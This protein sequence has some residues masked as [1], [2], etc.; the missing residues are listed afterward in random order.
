MTIIQTDS[1]LTFFFQFQV[2]GTLHISCC[3]DLENY[4]RITRNLQPKKIKPVKKHLKWRKWKREFRI[5][6]HQF[7]LKSK[8]GGRDDVVQ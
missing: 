6:L 7:Y 3:M 1:D 4:R 8:T 5:I 2:I